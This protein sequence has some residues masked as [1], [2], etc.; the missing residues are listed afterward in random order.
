LEERRTRR[1]TYQVQWRVD[2]VAQ[3]SVTHAPIW[4]LGVPGSASLESVNRLATPTKNHVEVAL[5][6]PQQLAALPALLVGLSVVQMACQSSN[7]VIWILTHGVQQPKVADALHAGHAGVWGLCRS[8][9]SEMPDLSVRCADII[10]NM[11]TI[12]RVDAISQSGMA[13]QTELETEATCGRNIV[14]VP[15]LMPIGNLSRP[16][17]VSCVLLG[18]PSTHLLTGGTGGLGLLTA[19]WLSQIAVSQ[20]HLVL[21]A[22]SAT[23]SARQL[24]ALA[25]SSTAMVDV[26]RRDAS[27]PTEIRSLNATMRSTAS[28]LCGIWHTAGVLAD[29]LLTNQDAGRL[30]RSYGPKALGASHLQRAHIADV[31]NA[32]VFFSSVAGLVGG[33]AQANYASANVCLD[34]IAVCRRSQG[35]QAVSISWGPWADAGMAADNA[36]NSRMSAMGLGSIDQ[37]QGLAALSAAIQPNRP[38][39]VAHWPVRWEV[40]LPHGKERAPPMLRELAA[41]TVSTKRASTAT[42]QLDVPEDA[43]SSISLDM[44]IDMA[45]RTAGTSIDADTPLLEAGLDSLGSV[46]LRNMLQQAVGD[47]TPLPSSLVLEYPT[48]RCIADFVAPMKSVEHIP[49]SRTVTEMVPLDLSVLSENLESAFQGDQTHPCLVRLRTAS[50]E[51]REVDLV[52]MHSFLGDELGYERLWKMNL[53][54]RSIFAVR[55][56]HLTHMGHSDAASSVTMLSSYAAALGAEFQSAPF[57]LIGASYGSLVAHHLSHAARRIGC[58]PRKLVLID[59]FPASPLIRET[60]RNSTLLSQQNDDPRSAAHFILKLRLHAQFGSEEGEAK[61]AIVMQELAAVPSDAVHLFL[62]A[63]SMPNATA[64]ELLIQAL[65]EHRRLLTVASIAPTIIDLVESI[66]PFVS[67]TGKPSILMVLSSERMAFYKDVYG[68]AGLEDQLDDYGAAVEPIPVEGEHFDVVARC[69][70]NRVPQFTSALERFLSDA[71]ID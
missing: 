3:R 16:A 18:K 40:L 52:I 13:S 5:L 67:S 49:C 4:A 10:T 8:V 54:N 24:V 60:A 69:I 71:E 48:A 42:P 27:E 20:L 30:R 14:A 51:G 28:P 11:Y 37:W 26:E 19:A 33:S 34:A 43:S 45:L 50:V 58:Q 17:E 63:Q 12:G 22:R 25:P 39:V 35:H 29:S 1:H 21:I 32:C 62:A 66:P 23:L 31:L 61:L 6:L 46:E 9:R 68:E 47:D 2:H 64:Q 38:V 56:P 65:R 53:S 41:N 15:R 36:V 7:K 59:P 55:H 57:D 44:V 70:S